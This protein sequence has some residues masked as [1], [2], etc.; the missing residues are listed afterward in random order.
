MEDS[1]GFR[2]DSDGLLTGAGALTLTR[3]PQNGLLTGSTLGSLTTSQGYTGYGERKGITASFGGTP[4]FQTLYTRDDAGRIRTLTETLGGQTRTFEYGYDGAG[5]LREVKQDGAV[6]TVYEY[7]DNG[8]RKRVTTTA[9]VVEAGT[10]A[11]D[12][13][14]SYG[15]ATY[16][17]TPAG[18]LEYRAVGSDTTRYKYDALGNLLEVVLPGGS[19]VEYVVDA[20]NRRVGR[21]VDGRMVQGFLWEGALRP[22]AEL[23]S[24]GAVVARFVYGERPN[25]PEYM[26]KGGRT[27]RLVQDHL[28]SVRLVV[29]VATGEVAQRIDYDAYGHV[30]QDSRPGFQPFGYAGGVYDER[31]GL[32]RFGARDYD[33]RTGRWTVPDPILFDGGSTNLYAYVDNAPTDQLDFD[34][35]QAYLADFATA[36]AGASSLRTAGLVGF[37]FGCISGGAIAPAGTTLWERGVRCLERGAVSAAFAVAMSVGV[38][39]M[40]IPAI[41]A[42]RPVVGESAVQNGLASGIVGCFTGFGSMAAG[43]TALGDEITQRDVVAAV[44]LGCM[45]GFA[46]GYSQSYGGYSYFS[47]SIMAS[48]FSWGSQIS[49]GMLNVTK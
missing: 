46:G 43:K 4:L 33:A 10:D 32:V 25:V 20:E 1:V 49:E 11:Q 8:N 9:G 7:D 42:I 17:Y 22:V 23:D 40:S 28:G 27:Y 39:Q 16:G 13:L 24:A 19:R 14:V 47:N 41:G 5:R 35:K 31:T 26:T 45:G 29:D 3:D 18:E 6:A 30:L 21:K 15:D 44:A 37:G 38:G 2:Y 34:G 36:Q 12:R 48:Y